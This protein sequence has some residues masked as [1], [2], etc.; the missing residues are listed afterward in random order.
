MAQLRSH[1]SGIPLLLLA[2]GNV[3][4]RFKSVE[5]YNEVDKELIG[6]K[7]FCIEA[8]HLNW[9][10]DSVQQPLLAMKMGANPGTSHASPSGHM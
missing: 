5:A 6:G 7:M 3:C 9:D 2:T 1:G 4:R 10:T 8:I